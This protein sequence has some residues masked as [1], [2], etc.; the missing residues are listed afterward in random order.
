[1][2]V[3]LSLSITS[4]S[5]SSVGVAIPPIAKDLAIDASTSSWVLTT[6][7]LA[8]TVFLVPL[9]KTADIMGRKRLF[10]LGNI[11]FAISSMLCGLSSSSSMILG[12]RMIQGIGGAMIF[13]TGIALI[14]SVFHPRERGRALGL[15]TSS[16]YI[17]LTTGPL[18]GGMLTE[19]FGWRSVF[20]FNVPI[21]GLVVALALLKLKE[22][23]TEAKGEELDIIGSAIYG[24]MVTLAITGLSQGHPT[25]VILGATLLGIFILW[26]LRREWPVLELRLFKNV[27]FAF[28]NLAALLNYS[29]TYAV[30]FIL[31]LYLQHIKGL[32]PQQAGLVLMAQPATQALLSPSAGYV[33]DRIEPR[34][35]ASIGM[36][37]TALGLWSL[38]YI[39]LETDITT[40]IAA[41]IIV[42]IGLAIFVSPNTKAIMGS[43]SSKFYGVASAMTATMRN[44]GQAVSMSIITLLMMLFLGE[45]AIIEPSTYQLFIDCSRSAF[46][47]FSSLCVVGMFAS[48]AR[49]V[50]KS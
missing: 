17:G 37:L 1:M 28:S 16:V 35:V 6:F 9:G 13:A 24:A 39:G 10:I 23:W 7:L 32:S 36:G 5:L 42:G 38:S 43:V 40:I 45:G 12:M 14:S 3:A 15:Y 41:L 48:I 4:S 11:I 25:L 46:Q 49:G 22:E 34:I 50:E 44:L 31:S 47:V 27:T 30:S 33:A 29:A 19:W 21:G 2:I 26:E 20:F 8:S 18:I